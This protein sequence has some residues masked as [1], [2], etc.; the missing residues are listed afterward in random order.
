MPMLN[1]T[2]DCYL[3]TLREPASQRAAR[4]DL[5]TFAR[6]WEEQ[7]GRV[8]D[9][10]QLLAKDISAWVRHRQDVEERKPATINRGLSTLRRFGEWLV[11]ERLL[12]EN[13]AKGVRD[14]PLEEHGPRSL[15]D[16]A[17]D[18]V[19]R[20][21]QA[22]E[23]SHI[24]L[25]DGAL[26]ALLAY[27][28]LRSQEACDVQLRDLDLDAGNV[29]V[30]RGK[31]RKTRRIPLHSDAVA[32]LRRYLHELRCP[33]GLPAIGSDAEREPLLVAQD[34]TKQ[35][36]PLVPGMS[37]RLV[38][39]RIA[40]LCQ[41]AAEQLRAAAKKEPRVERAGQFTQMASQLEAASPH[42]LRH[43]LARRMLRR[44]ADLS[45]VQRVLGHSRLSTTGIYTVPDDDDLRD[46]VERAGI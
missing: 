20:A 19:L 24:R 8:F 35:G 39:H 30:R 6:W 26:L 18:A 11:A 1:A 45:E 27:A 5:A 12:R 23:E 44:G 21:V 25:R 9:P 16:D 17:V 15:P 29:I 2:T 28:G 38:R 41:R 40:I 10:T 7:R 14:L 43:S 22:E 34:R 42:A 32:L 46:A 4:A 13:P 33:D 31:G 3:A 37:T 36:H